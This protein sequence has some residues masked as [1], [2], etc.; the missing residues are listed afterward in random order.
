MLI[1]ASIASSFMRNKWNNDFARPIMFL[2][3][4]INNH[5]Q[6]IAP[7]WIAKKNDIIL[8]YPNIIAIKPVPLLVVG[9]VGCMLLLVCGFSIKDTMNN[10]LETELSVIN[11]YKYRLN[12]V[13]DASSKRINELMDE[14]SHNSSKTLVVEVKKDGE[15]KLNSIL[16]NDS[17]DAVRTLDKDWKPMNIPEDGVIITQKLAEN[18]G[19]KLGEEIEWRNG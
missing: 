7:N 10:Y 8:L 6:I 19:L 2:D 1:S 11:N 18:E 14:Y 16:I 4:S 12:I 5:R 9:V 3:K 17:G 13:E 15:L